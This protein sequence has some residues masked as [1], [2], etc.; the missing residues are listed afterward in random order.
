MTSAFDRI[1]ELCAQ[2][3]MGK[4]EPTPQTL[5]VAR[6]SHP[7]HTFAGKPEGGLWTST[8][9]EQAQTAEWLDW[10]RSEEPGW[11]EPLQGWLLIP[12]HDASVYVIDG[13]ADLQRCISAYPRQDAAMRQF[14]DEHPTLRS[15]ML[16]REIDHEAIHAA[17]YVGFH[18]TSAG[19]HRTRHS[20]PDLYGWDVECTVWYEW[21]FADVRPVDAAIIHAVL[22]ANDEGEANA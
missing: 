12:Q 19:Q 17:G 18:L 16:A 10:L 2:L 3:W 22:P 4:Q 15:W 13:V 21:A 14:L 8:W 11:L 5:Q 20:Q 7:M 9:D 1:D 6:N